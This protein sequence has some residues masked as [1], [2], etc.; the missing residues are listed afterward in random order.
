[1]NGDTLQRMVSP[2]TRAVSLPALPFDLAA[3][4]R[5]TVSACGSAFYAGLV[6]RWRFETVA[7]LPA[8]GDVASEFHDRAPPMPHTREQGAKSVTLKQQPRSS[9]AS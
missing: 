1:V 4:P 3:A 7:R 5:V 6:G 9:R 2:A 8:D